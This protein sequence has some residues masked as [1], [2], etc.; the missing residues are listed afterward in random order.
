MPDRDQCAVCLLLRSMISHTFLQLNPVSLAGLQFSH[1]GYAYFSIHDF[2]IMYTV[3][4]SNLEGP[5]PG[6]TII[7][8]LN[9]QQLELLDRTIATGIAADRQSLVKLAIREQAERQTK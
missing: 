9:Q 2:H 8:K 7:L 3:Y 1:T 4:V 5:M 6:K